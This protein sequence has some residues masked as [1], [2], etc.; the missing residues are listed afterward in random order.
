[1][2][3]KIILFSSILFL[4]FLQIASI[5]AITIVDKPVGSPTDFGAGWQRSEYG[6]TILLRWSAGNGEIRDDQNPNIR[7]TEAN[8]RLKRNPPFTDNKTREIRGGGGFSGDFGYGGA[9]NQGGSYFDYDNI[10]KDQQY[11]YTLWAVDPDT[12]RESSPITASVTVKLDTPSCPEFK[13]YGTMVGDNS[14][15]I[16]WPEKICGADRYKIKYN[17]S[18]TYWWESLSNKNVK[19]EE[20]LTKDT[21][22]YIIN[23]LE[24]GTY[25]VF[26]EPQIIVDQ[27]KGEI[28]AIATD[29]LKFTLNK[30]AK[31]DPIGCSPPDGPFKDGNGMIHV[32]VYNDK[33]ERSG[34]YPSWYPGNYWWWGPEWGFSGPMGTVA[35][36]STVTVSSPGSTQNMD[37]GFDWGRVGSWEIRSFSHGQIGGRVGLFAIFVTASG[38]KEIQPLDDQ[39]NP[40]SQVL[41][42]STGKFKLKTSDRYDSYVNIWS[43]HGLYDGTKKII[44]EA[45]VATTINNRKLHKA[46][47]E[48]EYSSGL[49][50]P[51]RFK[52]YNG[53][54][55]C[56][57]LIGPQEVELVRLDVNT[58]AGHTVRM[59]K[60]DTRISKVRI[61]ALKTF[62]SGTQEAAAGRKLAIKD[63][64]KSALSFADSEKELKEGYKEE[65][66]TTDSKGEVTLYVLSGRNEQKF[67]IRDS[68]VS[69]A[70]AKNMAVIP[71]IPA[72]LKTE[73]DT[74]TFKKD[75]LGINTRGMVK[76][77]KTSTANITITAY[78]AISP[79]V[80]VT[81]EG[82]NLPA[83]LPKPQIALTDVTGAQ[84]QAITLDENNQFKANTDGLGNLNFAL[85]IP[86]EALDVSGKVGPGYTIKSKSLINDE[87]EIDELFIPINYIAKANLIMDPTLPEGTDR[88]NVIVPSGTQ[89]PLK[90]SVDRFYEKEPDNA[91]SEIITV[92]VEEMPIELRIEGYRLSNDADKIKQA[93]D[94]AKWKGLGWW[95]TTAQYDPVDDSHGRGTWLFENITKDLLGSDFSLEKFKTDSEGNA[96]ITVILPFDIAPV[97]DGSPFKITALVYDRDL[98]NWWDRWQQQK[99][100]LKL[101]LRK[102]VAEIIPPDL[103]NIV[104]TPTIIKILEKFKDDST[105]PLADA[106]VLLQ[107]EV[108]KNR[109]PVLGLGLE[110]VSETVSTAVTTE[111]QETT[112]AT[113]TQNT[114]QLLTEVNELTDPNGEYHFN[115]FN[116]SSLRFPTIPLSLK[117]AAAK[118]G[119]E[120]ITVNDT[121]NVLTQINLKAP[122]ALHIRQSNLTGDSFKI[123]SK[124]TTAFGDPIDW[125]FHEQL[126]ADEETGLED[127]GR[128]ETTQVWLK[129]DHDIGNNLEGVGTNHLDVSPEVVKI[130]GAVTEFSYN[131]QVPTLSQLVTTVTLPNNSGYGSFAEISK[132][133]LT[134]PTEPAPEP[135]PK[136]E[137]EI[138]QPTPGTSFQWQ[139]Q[140][141]IDT[142]VDAQVYDLDA[143]DTS[144][145]TVKAL[146]DQNRKVICYVNVGAWE[147]FRADQ[148][149]FA[150]EIKGNVYSADYPNEKWL[151]ISKLDILSPLIKKR[152]ELCKEK[153]FDAIEPDNID[154][155][156]QATGFNLTAEDQL[157][158]NKHL[159]ELAHNLGLSIGLKNDGDQVSDLINQ[160]DWALVESC[161]ADDFCDEFKPFTDA[162]KA[163]FMTEYISRYT[164]KDVAAALAEFCPKAKELNFFAIYKNKAA[165]KDLDAYREI[166]PQE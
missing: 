18:Y 71:R 68:S 66:I 30:K 129:Y 163:V 42:G 52:G 34:I 90:F 14:V 8:Y 158:F 29:T 136:S 78:L 131:E 57:Q 11:D 5:K 145:E 76:G 10:Q 132:V 138:W 64:Y 127:L 137:Q 102:M 143:F 37:A 141:E 61:K 80:I 81:V 126:R 43:N 69:S 55:S 148:A 82:K 144:V 40:A 118:L 27:E 89:I 28:E 67:D 1:M 110:Q 20:I 156:Q 98:E 128:Y 112:T 95:T 9:F 142:T 7:A 139:L 31:D 151:D 135:Q 146:H 22:E 104:P 21:K 26:V 6:V 84:T 96:E 38:E 108:P 49:I 72:P 165:E 60:N 116:I 79:E 44:S 19:K 46:T 149:D 85:T 2:K 99:L 47:Y 92:S 83:G 117:V 157:N 161:F 36:G 54:G 133:D 134:L 94:A 106:K 23:S 32:P 120:N 162:G 4:S 122:L 155:Y 65:E 48:Q 153:G 15:K 97:S 12:G 105:A 154:G 130:D 17:T 70:F 150:E 111:N 87:E 16:F 33:G 88:N 77:D 58:E 35:L 41:V 160:F 13:I 121:D 140:G 63:F 51:I 25:Q 125:L 152:F 115:L 119:Y 100:E 50:G 164:G 124:L 166:C 73:S 159:A 114:S 3:R 107:L 103:T 53:R 75:V 123:T 74:K 109:L 101:A 113:S 62:G 86:S 59:I 93:K 45:L 91:A 24:P 39:G 147:D 56:G